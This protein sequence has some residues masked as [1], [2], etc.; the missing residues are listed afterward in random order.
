MQ[1]FLL[2]IVGSLIS[3]VII[4]AGP[5]IL[6]VIWLNRRQRQLAEFFGLNSSIREVR[7]LLSRYWPEGNSEVLRT[8][9]ESLGF[10]GETVAVDEFRGAQDIEKLFDSG[11]IVASLASVIGGSLIGRRDFGSIRVSVSPV[12]SDRPEKSTVVLMGT[13]AKDSNRLAAEILGPD[14]RHSIFRFVKDEHGRAFERMAMHHFPQEK[15]YASKYEP[16]ELAVLQR[17]TMADGTVTFLC[18]GK[19]AAGSRMAAEFLSANWALFYEQYHS[20]NNGDF[21][22]LYVF[23]HSAEEPQLLTNWP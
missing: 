2:G 22:R 10:R 23:S 3:A 17:I 20:Q 19:D 9:V 1:E 8:G 11:W 4:A 7:I 14:A 13:G 16:G 18:A 6:G 5:I 12:A 21:A 15:F